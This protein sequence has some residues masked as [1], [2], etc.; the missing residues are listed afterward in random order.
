MDEC[1]EISAWLRGKN[2]FFH[3]SSSRFSTLNGCVISLKVS[4]LQFPCLQ[5]RGLKIPE[6]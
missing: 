4:E 5:S 3:P 2:Q 1:F 6:P